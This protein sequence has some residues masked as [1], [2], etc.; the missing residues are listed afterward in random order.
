MVVYEVGETVTIPIDIELDYDGVTQ[1]FETEGEDGTIV[2]RVFT[3]INPD[4]QEDVYTYYVSLPETYDILSSSGTVDIS[5]NTFW[6]SQYELD[7]TTFEVESLPV[8]SSEISTGLRENSNISAGN[9]A[10]GSAIASSIPNND[11]LFKET[12]DNLLGLLVSNDSLIN[13]FKY[14]PNDPE[15]INNVI[16]QLTGSSLLSGDSNV[17]VAFM[18]SLQTQQSKTSSVSADL[19]DS[20]DSSFENVNTSNLNAASQIDAFFAS[21][22]DAPGLDN[23]LVSAEGYTPQDWDSIEPDA[24]DVSTVQATEDEQAQSLFPSLD[25]DTVI[26]TGLVPSY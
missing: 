1:T 17:I 24:P 26:S 4:T 16:S 11:P 5:T 18:E 9:V 21:I 10:T 14:N 8:T 3:T 25:P 12:V 23:L 13:S 6:F 20:E 22:N 19:A 2:S 15:S 7:G